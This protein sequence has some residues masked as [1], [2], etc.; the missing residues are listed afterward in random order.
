MA[1]A[2]SALGQNS[3]MRRSQRM[4]NYDFWLKSALEA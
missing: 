1:R 2:G 4:P 3:A